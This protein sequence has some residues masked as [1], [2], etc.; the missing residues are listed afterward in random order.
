[1]SDVIHR[2]ADEAGVAA[3]VAAA[4][5]ASTPLEL[6][7][8]GSR[9]GFG[10]PMQTAA[11]LDLSALTGI[12]LYEPAEMV[13][14]ARAGTP[15]ADLVAALD[16]K[17]QMLPF[18]PMDWRALMGTTNTVPTVGGL[19]AGNVSGPRRV[20]VGAA[21]DHLIGVRFVNG[22]GEIIKNGGRVMKNVTGYDIVKLMAGSHGTL[23]ALTEVIFKVLPKPETEATLVYERE[24]FDHAI[25]L[26]GEAL[27]SPFEVS[28]AAYIPAMD[29]APARTLLRLENFADSITY[30]SEKL[31][32]RLAAHGWP[33]RLDAAESR[34]IWSA[35]RDV[36]M[37]A[38][39]PELAVIRVSV[40][41]SRG[42]AIRDAAVSHGATHG[43][44]DWGGG[45]IWI[46]VP[47]AR[48]AAVLEAVRGAIRLTGGHATLVRASDAARLSLAVFEPET[49]PVAALSQRIKATFD[50]A[51]ILNPGRMVAGL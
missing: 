26:M 16:A 5:A 51:G 10:R 37:L 4:H 46:G 18:E 8:G 21:R 27:G 25:D 48:L 44:A 35:I 47:E 23:G 50:P 36:T 24:G 33:K 41:P 22:R 38:E 40:A 34:A 17:G 20:A 1:M 12:T 28:G 32:D 13:I 45:L 2:P 49:A 42:V 39:R 19:V 30:R 15:V 31:A 11:T 14:G 9:R 3:V 7:G 29:G 43:F 6:R